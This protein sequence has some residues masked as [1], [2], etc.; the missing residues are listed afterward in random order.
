MP[1]FWVRWRTA[2]EWNLRSTSRMQ[3]E[4]AFWRGGR[5]AIVRWVC[6][7]LC[8]FGL[9]EKSRGLKDTEKSVS[10]CGE[11]N[12]AYSQKFSLKKLCVTNN[13]W[14]G[15]SEWEQVSER[16]ACACKQI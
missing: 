11:C 8:A 10:E 5:I 3:G 16:L 7:F 14:W 15:K 4:R 1:P 12:E 9:S 2:R 6:W 13:F